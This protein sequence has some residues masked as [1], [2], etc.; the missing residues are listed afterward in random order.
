MAKGRRGMSWTTRRRAAE[1]FADCWFELGQADSSGNLYKTK[2]GPHD[3][4]AIMPERK[5]KIP[6]F[7]F[8]NGKMGKLPDSEVEVPIQPEF[9]IIIDAN[10]LPIT[11]VETAP[12]RIERR[13]RDEARDQK[14]LERL[15]KLSKM[16]S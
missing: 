5:A 1:K 10:T 6:R 2:V 4:L 11:L 16:V 15:M 12:Q 13:R 14:R 3:V 8:V 7:E 9:E